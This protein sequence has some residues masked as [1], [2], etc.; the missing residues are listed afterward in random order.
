MHAG[1]WW[2]AIVVV[3]ALLAHAFVVIRHLPEPE[4]AGD[5][6]PYATLFGPGAIIGMAV[7][8][9]LLQCSAGHAPVHVRLAMMVWFS[10]VLVL[11]AVDL[12]TTWL[13]LTL[14]RWCGGELA[15]AILAGAMLD[16]GRAWWTMGGALAGGGAAYG[17]FW[18]MWRVS[19]SLGFGDV[20]LA[21]MAGA[22]S[23]AWSFDA[24][25]WTML[26]ATLIGAGWGIVTSLLRR[27]RS[28]PPG[29]F[30]YGPALWA[31]PPVVVVFSLLAG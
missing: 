18:V 5:K 25:W 2:L 3:M 28:Q 9:F 4:D 19:Q 1:W 26:A 6:P 8:S 14:T 16:P 7:A 20:R 21:A 24:W 15:V 11:A 22:L 12:R 30:A 31:G 17:F 10:S 29:P 23:G 13:P 27:R